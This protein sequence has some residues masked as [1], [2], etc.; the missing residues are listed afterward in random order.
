PGGDWCPRRARPPDADRHGILHGLGRRWVDSL[1][2]DGPRCRR[3]GPMGHPRWAVCAGR[4]R[5]GLKPL[6][7]APGGPAASVDG[8][9]RPPGPTPSRGS[10][11]G[12]GGP[13]RGGWVTG[14]GWGGG[15]GGTTR[16]SLAPARDNRR[17]RP[18]E[19]LEL[20]RA[21]GHDRPRPLPRPR[22]RA[23]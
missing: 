19:L 12:G 20:A 16:A 4:G 17:D 2:P 7:I 14:G 22:T 21:A 5:T 11:G 3:P 1:A 23:G 13:G 18:Y 10:P 8:T 6:R 9:G 15:R